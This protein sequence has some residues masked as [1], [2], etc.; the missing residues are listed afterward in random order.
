VRSPLP[1]IN[2]VK[3]AGAI[4]AEDNADQYAVVIGVFRPCDCVT[5]FPPRAA[6]VA[7]ANATHPAILHVLYGAGVQVVQ[8]PRVCA[9]EH[10]RDEVTLVAP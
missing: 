1:E 6:G 2:F 9:T 7:E 8:K 4:G 3:A 5:K 10:D